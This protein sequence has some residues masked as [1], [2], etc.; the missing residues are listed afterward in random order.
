[1]LISDNYFTKEGRDVQEFEPELEPGRTVQGIVN[2]AIVKK[3]LITAASAE[4][5]D[6]MALYVSDDAI[7]WHRAEF[8]HDHRLYQEA[9]TVLEGTNYSVQIDVMNTRPS[10]P[11]GVLFSSN[12]NGT[13]FT[14]N[15]EHTNRIHNGLVDFEKMSGVQGILLVNTVWNWEECEAS[16]RPKTLRSQISFDDGRTWQPLE[17]PDGIRLHLHS[18]T[19]LSNVGRVFSSPAPGLVMGNGNVGNHIQ[20]LDQANLYVS[21]DAGLTWILGLEG[22]HKYEIGDQGSILVAVKEGY[23]NKVRYSLNHGKKWHKAKL[24]RK[25]RPLEL[26]TTQDSTS[27]KFI[28]V[29]FDDNDEDDSKNYIITLD[30]DDMQER[31]CKDEDMEEWHARVDEDG[32]PTC[33]MGHTQSYRRRKADAD[34]FLKKEFRQPVVITKQCD[35]TDE[36]FECDFNFIRSDDRKECKRAGSLVLP[37]GACRAFGP[38][39]TFMGSSGWRLIPGNDCKRVG[40]EQKDDPIP[41]KCSEAMGAPMSAEIEHTQKAFDGSHSSKHYLERTGISKGDDETIL[42]RTDEG[43]VWLT[44][45]HGKKWE[46]VLKDEKILSIY[47]HGYFKDVVYFLTPTERVFY[48]VDRGDNIHSFEAPLPPHRSCPAMTFHPK[49]KDWIIWT[50][51]KDCDSGRLDDCHC[52]SSISFDRGDDWQTLQRYVKKCEFIK[53]SDERQREKQDQDHVDQ[54]IYCER[55]QHENNHKDNPFQLV[56]SYDFFKEQPTVHFTNVV[57]FATMSEFIVVATKDEEHETLRVDTSVDAEIFATAEFPHG[58]QIDH[59]KAYT[60]LDSSTHSV[61][62]HVTV[63]DEGGYEYGTI[64]KSNSNGTSYVLSANAVDRDATGYVDF[65]KMLGLEG[66]AMINVVSNYASKNYKKEGKKLKTMITHNDGAEWDYLP[67]PKKD[68]DGKSYCKGSPEKCSLHIHGYTE[69]SDKSHTFSSTS[70]VGIM[71]GVG[72]V[73]DKLESYVEADT[74][75][76]S[77]GGINWKFVKKGPYMWEFGDQGSIIVIVKEQDPTNHIFYSLDEGD[78][79]FEYQFSDFDMEIIDLTTVPSDNAKDFLLW[80]DNDGSLA[81][82]NIDFSGLR[83]ESCVLDEADPEKGDYWLWQPRHPKLKDDCLFGHVAQYHRKKVSSECWNGK[84]VPHLHNI[85]RNCRCTRRD[86]EW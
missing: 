11:M 48:S 28:L 80:A 66:V 17:G 52:V 81:T 58:F 44:H 86:F 16:N 25:I 69:R 60:V 4:G 45:D 3:Y 68:G 83:N 46:Q 78:N 1:M 35:C 57:D 15:I 49:N 70:A 12:S 61:F 64:I 22:P 36:D 59:Q 38:D 71:M 62:L 74:F 63:D 26:T 73:G 8:P 79:W 21:D 42:M 51:G 2:M 50:G 54:L 47:T 56:S 75:M 34:C 29:A 27:L 10:N 20:K 41:R 53:E 37:A 23:T 55:K 65:E 7:K 39:D 76:T 85:A 30:F 72:N 5:T 18:V 82:I 13:Y 31:Q 32:N 77:D 84:M 14:R 9:Y 33:L 24:P 19:E 40:R 67:P 6:E 43:Q